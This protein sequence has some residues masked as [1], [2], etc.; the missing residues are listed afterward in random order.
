[1]ILQKNLGIALDIGTTT[2]KGRLIDLETDEGLSYFSS[3]NEQLTLGHDVISR[4]KFA[5]EKPK[6]LEKLNKRIISS[7]NFVVENLLSSAKKERDDISLIVCVGNAALYH[8]TLS[9]SPE[10]L[11]KPP[12][13]PAYKDF[14]SKKAKD[15]GIKVSGRCELNFLPNIGGFVGSDAI[16]V[17]LASGLDSSEDPILAVDIG[18]NGEIIVG[19][20]ERILVTS[21]AAGP[22]FEG[23]HIN[24]GMRPVEGAIESVNDKNGDLKLKIIGDAE[25]KGIS[26]SGLIDMVGILLKRG[27]IDKSGTLERD[28]VICDRPKKVFLSQSDVRQVQLAK[29][30]F[31]AGIRYLTRLSKKKITRLFITGNFGGGIDKENAETVGIIPENIDARN[32]AVLEDGALRGAEIFLGDRETVMPR[33]DGILEKTEHISLGQNSDFEREFIESMKF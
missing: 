30:A 29:A 24:C 12:Y 8:F 18:T 27:T 16:A 9:L 21:T 31:K 10:N 1:M 2:I 7:I 33:I 3:L 5:L 19:S 32:V 25:P 23:W 6:G 13:E 20:K 26:G 15:L 17:I 14:V 4:I 28:F 11:V 22:A